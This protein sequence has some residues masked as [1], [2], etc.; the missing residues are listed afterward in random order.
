M[1][2]RH[3][4]TLIELL[5][6]IAIIAILA[7]ILF[8]VFERARAKA[9][10][11]SCQS[12]LKQIGLAF[13]MYAQDYDGLFPEGDMLFRRADWPYNLNEWD[14]HYDPCPGKSG[15]AFYIAPYVKT[16]AIFMCPSGPTHNQ[17]DGLRRSYG[18][19][20]QGTHLRVCGAYG[21]IEFPAETYLVCDAAYPYLSRKGCTLHWLQTWLGHFQTNPK[22]QGH[23]HN[24]MHNVAF[25]D[26]H[27]KSVSQNAIL[28]NAGGAAN[29]NIPPWN[30]PAWED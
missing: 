25:C 18:W 22:Y 8:P 20:Y 9:Q 17:D 24:G 23:R 27:V 21:G 14:I 2:C 13:L 3:G 7:A 30:W 16:A 10:S 12:Q 28:E 4:F 1:K 19:N 29:N 6:V 26:G 5:V 15:W 11:A